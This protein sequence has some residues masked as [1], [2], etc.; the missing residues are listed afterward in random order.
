MKKG[1]KIRVLGIFDD[2]LQ[3]SQGTNTILHCF[4]I[5]YIDLYRY[6]LF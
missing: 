3:F 4:K 2:A 6:H 5:R 1:K